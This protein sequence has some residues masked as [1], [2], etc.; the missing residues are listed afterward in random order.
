MPKMR[1]QIY[2]LTVAD[3]DDCPVWEFALDEEGDEG[4]DECTVRPCLV[5]DRL[6]PSRGGFVVRARFTLPDES[7]LVGFMTPPV[8]GDS[9]LGVLQPVVITTKGH[10]GFWCGVIAPD[11]ASIAASYARLDR[12]TASQVF[13]LHFESDVPLVDGPVR[14]QL[15]GFLL[16]EDMQAHRVRVVR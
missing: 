11:A 1:K 10:V 16:L 13:P 15:D 2:D 9:S 4:Q 3:L 5:G 7:A 14:G 8:R 12:S 6:D